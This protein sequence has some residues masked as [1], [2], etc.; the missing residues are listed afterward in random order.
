MKTSPRQSLRLQPTL[1]LSLG[2]NLDCDH[3]STFR[4]P[5]DCSVL[6]PRNTLP[7]L[8]RLNSADGHPSHRAVVWLAEGGGDGRTDGWF[9]DGRQST[10][11][12]PHTSSP[13][14]CCT[15]ACT[16]LRN[17]NFLALVGRH[18]A[19]RR[20]VAASECCRRHKSSRHIPPSKP[21]PKSQY[22]RRPTLHIS[23]QHGQR[24]PVAE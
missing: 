10:P 8:V 17:A 19:R 18:F 1:P 16:I 15:C 24:A 21:K 5:P 14:S 11:L 6:T 3:W 20:A 2:S 23:A 7:V 22:H 4:P 12:P 13:S 9:G